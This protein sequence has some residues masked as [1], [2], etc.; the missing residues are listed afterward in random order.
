[1]HETTVVALALVVTLTLLS[2]ECSVGGRAAEN[3]RATPKRSI[4]RLAP[5]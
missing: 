3:D 4:A 1:M 5:T 2:S